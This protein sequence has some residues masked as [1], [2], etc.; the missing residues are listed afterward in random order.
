MTDRHRGDAPN[1]GANDGAR[2][3]NVSSTPYRDFRPSVQ[4]SS[5]LFKDTST[6]ES[7]DCDEP[8]K[9]FGLTVPPLVPAAEKSRILPTGGFVII[10]K[11]ESQGVLRAPNF[12]FRPSHADALHLDFWHRG[13]NLLRDGGSY[14]YNSEPR[15]HHYFTGS[16]SHNTVQF[17]GHDQMPRLGRFL[18]G[19]WLKMDESSNLSEDDNKMSWS[20]AYTDYAGCHHRRTV[21][22]KKG[23]WRI[24]DDVRGYKQKAILRWRLMPETWDISGLM[25]H[26]RQAKL[27][28]TTEGSL[29]RLELV[30]G[31]ESRH[32][33]EKTKLPVLEVEAGPPEARFITTVELKG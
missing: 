21:E 10:R 20:G 17:D 12:R 16:E 32:Y 7:G 1:I 11:G 26:G 4:L 13:E 8:L 14:S 15:W 5:V 23:F 27:E 6:F 22:A 25:C 2:L 29:H 24:I 9:W 28:V 33:F 18:F 30:T 31:W 3:Y 19:A